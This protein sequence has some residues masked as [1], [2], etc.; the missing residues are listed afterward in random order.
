M[1]IKLL[2]NGD[3]HDDL[4]AEGKVVEATQSRTGYTVTMDALAEAG[5]APVIDEYYFFRSEVELP[6]HTHA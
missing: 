2:T 1:K 6:W 3:Y 5:A 4:N